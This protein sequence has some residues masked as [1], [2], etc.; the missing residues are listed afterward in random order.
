MKTT[1]KNNAT[2]PTDGQRMT[3]TAKL[4][5]LAEG[6]NR[7]ELARG[8]GLKATLLSDYINKGYMPRADIAL[9]IARA[10]GVDVAWLIDDA[11]PWPP[12]APHLAIVAAG[13]V[14]I[15]ASAEGVTVISAP[16]GVSVRIDYPKD[17]ASAR[18]LS[19][20]RGASLGQS[21]G[22]PQGCAA[23]GLEARRDC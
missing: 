16:P 3:L 12:P 1:A 19:V 14:R 10:L 8:V 13:E 4:S 2:K 20:S 11:A 17:T 7:A 18:A 21:A 23:D 22:T 5:A 15:A 9:K 6:K